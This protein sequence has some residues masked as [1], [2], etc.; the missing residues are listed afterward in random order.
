MEIHKITLIISDKKLAEIA[1][2]IMMEKYTGNLVPDILPAQDLAITICQG[3][4]HDLD[5][6]ILKYDEEVH[7]ILEKAEEKDPEK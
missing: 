7:K 2:F 4:R 3:I 1:N 5:M 6:V